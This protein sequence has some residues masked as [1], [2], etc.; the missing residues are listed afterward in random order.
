MSRVLMVVLLLTLVACPKPS[1]VVIEYG[2]SAV[3]P[4]E[5]VPG[6]TISVFG[7][8]PAGA[9]ITLDGVAVS[10]TPIT[11]GVSIRLP[12]EVS[13]GQRTLQF[14]AAVLTEPLETVVNLVP[15]VNTALLNGSALLVS[16]VGWATTGGLDATLTLNGRALNTTRQGQDLLASL[17]NGLPF[18]ALDVQVVVGGAVS[19]TVRLAREA[20]AVRGTVQMP[21]STSSVTPPVRLQALAAESKSMTVF[22]T[23]WV[24]LQTL[25]LSDLQSHLEVR[26]LKAVQ[27]QFTSIAAAKAAWIRLGQKRFKTEWASWFA[28]ADGITATSGV[29]AP[30]SPG[31]GQWHLN[32]MGLTAV[33][34]A[35]KGAGVTV[36]VVDTG[37]DLTH[38]DLINTIL[39]GYDFVDLD[40]EAM[41]I[42][43][44]GS[45]VA[46]LIAANGLALG[47]APAAKIVPIRVLRDLNGG[48]D[49]PVAEGILWAAG[50]LEGQPNPNPAQIINLSLGSNTFSNLIAD[51]IARVLA[52]GVIVLAA[53]GNNGSSAL[54]FPAALPGVIAV[55]ALAG[56]STL[57]QPGYAQKGDGVWVS[58]FGGDM[59]ADQNRDGIPD[60][61]LSLD[62]AGGYAL[63]NGTSM[64][65]PVAAG[66]AAL[67]I[68][69]GTP[70]RLVRDALAKTALDLGAR[71][72]D[73]R[74][75][76]GLVNAQ[77]GQSLSPRSYALILDS[78][79][80]IVT[81]SVITADSS[82]LIG[83]LE[84]NQANSL[85]IASDTDGDA[86]LGEAGEFISAATAITV[87]SAQIL[88]V[89]TIN[90]T[91]STGSTTYTL[92]ATR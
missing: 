12:L 32:L 72:Y 35:T 60:G 31:A 47:V 23:T 5:A 86:I 63:R 88:D 46:G 3:I 14:K 29:A 30:S 25:A 55:T 64:A 58:A 34:N 24:D 4:N 67:A 13:A 76:Y 49:G 52:K 15:R 53:A 84:T 33:W 26:T 41:D 57:Y 91:I 38:P 74:Y 85:V 22:N 59:A 18:G 73:T 87:Q 8:L 9:T 66:V 80:K 70:Q 21:A 62:I 39:S 90:L 89:G 19:N 37:V 1:K 2:I 28:P 40:S 20:G 56:P 61:I 65:T 71:G 81:W 68:S 79:G 17:P 92:E 50:L 11:D 82:F 10:A 75:G 44:H 43:G 69:G 7:V 77:I 27:L 16:G 51:A 6:D 45:H 36:A 78:A 48:S 54:A 42:A 83:N